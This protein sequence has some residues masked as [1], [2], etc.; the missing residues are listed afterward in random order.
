LSF[1]IIYLSSVS[2]HKKSE[3][4]KIDEYRKQAENIVEKN[5]RIYI[6]ILLQT[7]WK[8][9]NYCILIFYYM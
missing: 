2:V 3:K 7:R 9:F 5:I 8:L 4:L 1:I 6:A